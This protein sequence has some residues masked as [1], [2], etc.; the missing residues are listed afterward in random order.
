MQLAKGLQQLHAMRILHLDI[1]PQN[2]LVDQHGDVGISDFGISYQ[3]QS[4]LSHFAASANMVGTPNYMYVHR[5]TLQPN[6]TVLTTRR[7]IYVATYACIPENVVAVHVMYGSDFSNRQTIQGWAIFRLVSRRWIVCRSPE[8]VGM[9][10]AGVQLEFA[11]DVWSGLTL[12]QIINALSVQHRSPPVPESL[13]AALRGKLRRCFA[14]EP[15]ARPRLGE[16]VQM[17][18]VRGTVFQHQCHAILCD[19]NAASVNVQW[20]IWQSN[21]HAFIWCWDENN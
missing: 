21:T 3:M 13:P 8:A 1:K 16:I 18:Q 20:M 12:M 10:D 5:P 7:V 14:F 19:A 9:G 11:A 6:K 2:V 17:L 4:T 15:N